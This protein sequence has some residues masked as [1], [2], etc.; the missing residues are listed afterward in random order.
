MFLA[1]ALVAVHVV[2]PSFGIW[3]V[4]P[5]PRAHGER[6]IA[7]M[8]QGLHAHGAVWDQKRAE[9]LE[10]I[11]AAR[12]RGEVNEIIADALTVAGGPHSFLL[13]DAEQQQIEQDYQAPTHRTD[14]GV[15][16]VGLPR[17]HGHSGPGA[18]VRR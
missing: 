10:A 9:A 17:V 1:L 18:V 2:G 8:G 13:T 11:T 12:S 15:V 4:P 3:L 5:S 7:L 6:A 16:T 14:G